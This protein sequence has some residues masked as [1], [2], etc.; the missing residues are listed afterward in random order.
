[1]AIVAGLKGEDQKIM[2]IFIDRCKISPGITSVRHLSSGSV[3]SVFKQKESQTSL[4]K[5]IY[6]MERFQTFMT[7]LIPN[8]ITPLL[9]FSLPEPGYPNKPNSAANAQPPC[10]SSPILSIQ[11]QV[12]RR[13]QEH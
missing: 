8:Q 3:C 4:E 6:N 12:R 1:M 10:T 9:V 2:T 7:I 13:N 11:D 5:L